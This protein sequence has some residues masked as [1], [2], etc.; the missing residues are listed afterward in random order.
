VAL[1]AWDMFPVQALTILRV[2]LFATFGLVLWVLLQTLSAAYPRWDRTTFDTLFESPV[3]RSSGPGELQAIRR[4]ISLSESSALDAHSRIAPLLRDI[5]DAHL[6]AR[7]GRGLEVGPE[8]VRTW[9]G[10]LVWEAVRPRV[11]P[12]RDTPGMSL[13]DIDN[14]VVAL[15]EFARS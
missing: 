11:L 6:K 15:E 13:S 7:Y 5:A 4:A 8:Q 1:V 10:P 3:I 2:Y 9:L 14:V 12:D